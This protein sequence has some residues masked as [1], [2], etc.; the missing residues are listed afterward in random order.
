[1]FEPACPP[2]PSTSRRAGRLACMLA[3]MAAASAAWSAPAEISL[4][5]PADGI[6]PALLHVSGLA[7]DGC[8]PELRSIDIDGRD[9][10]IRAMTSADTC[11][12]KAQ[13]FTLSS[14][15][16]PEP[17]VFPEP[18]VY[19]LRFESQAGAD[20]TPQLEAFRLVE[21]GAQARV[22]PE[23]GFWWGE[24]GAEFDRA[25]PGFGVQLEV[26]AGT[27]A[28]SVSGYA[29]DGNP[30]WLFGA[31]P[32]LG[33]TAT[34]GLGALRGG[35]APYG[36]F[37]GPERI[38]ESGRVHIEWL[39]TARALFWFE[40]AALDG[41]GI[42]LQP[43]SMVRFGFA[44]VA[45]VAGERWLG[46]WLLAAT[47]IDG[48]AAIATRALDFVRIEPGSE[49]FTMHAASGERLDCRVDPGRPASPPEFCRLE[50]PG[51]PA[52]EFSDVALT[53]LTGTTDSERGTGTA[54][55]MRV[56]A[57]ESR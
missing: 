38:D 27:A 18:G 13:P 19:R 45:G 9:V 24:Q 14:R 41:R 34:I 51:E 10:V 8:L 11:F 3:S 6:G 31:A 49:G 32:M 25:G 16:L 4:Q 29:D 47:D 35:R 43:V 17:L 22:V 42:E 7:E 1:M 54:V 21:V 37:R 5:V 12:A 44:G 48:D 55:L 50:Q 39:G 52:V 26:Q 28:I 2:C 46:R 53:R 33:G 20:A 56:E 15:E 57:G 23:A 30:Q 40:R 36:R